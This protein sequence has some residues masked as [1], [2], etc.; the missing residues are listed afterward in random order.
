MCGLH[1]IVT[2]KREINGDDFISSAF[3]ANMLR[4]VDS[5]GIAT[6][7]TSTNVYDYHKLPV[8][9]L[10]FAEDKVAKPIIRAASNANTIT[11][12]H[13]RAA[14]VGSIN[15]NNAHPFTIE[16]EDRTVI[17]MHNGTLTGWKSHKNAKDFDVD[18]EWAINHIADKGYEA[19]EDFRGAF[20]FVWWDSDTPGILNIARNS[21]RP[22][23]VA[24]LKS[25]GM[26]YASEAGMLHWLL[27]RHKVEVDGPI[28][29][30]DEDHWYKFDVSDPA[31]FTK[32]KLPKTV[33]TT[34]SYGSY[35]SSNYSSGSYSIMSRVND[36]L[37]RV[38][39][40][41]KE[42]K[43]TSNV[44][45]L[46]P[47]RHHLVSQEEYDAAKSSNLL[48]AAAK[49]EPISEWDDGIDGIATV[50]GAE[51]MAFVR[52]FSAAFKSDEEWTCRVIGVQDDGTDINLV[53]SPP[54]LMDSKEKV[55]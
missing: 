16:E 23:Y 51:V 43:E 48:G 50:E 36:F 18:S 7:D 35:Y 42:E 38:S 44:T 30:L 29:K 6:I 37:K 14:T 15:I 54:S 33:Y 5:S 26:A 52:G 2:S 19:F 28:L 12:C 40:G 41:K 46:V 49:F 45:S 31:D 21:E 20:C 3:T 27:E 32:V 9:G 24:M 8:A 4:G 47:A 39:S 11:M 13:V 25:G 22:M 10:Y 1:G 53:L 55:H 17:G 34:T